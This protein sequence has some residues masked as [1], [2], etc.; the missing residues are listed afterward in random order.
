MAGMKTATVLKHVEFEGPSRISSILR[1]EG[2]ELDVR[3][4]HRGDPVPPAGAGG[5]LLVVMGG[6]MGV[7]DLGRPEYAF[8]RAEVD[9][10]RRRIEDDA[11]VLGVC[12]G[13]QLLAHAA[14]ARVYPMTGHDG[15]RRLEVGWG[16][17]RLLRGDDGLLDGLPSEVV[18]LHWHGD[19]FDVPAG[20]RLLASSEI[21]P[22]QA[23]R[24]RRSLFGLQ[25]HCESTAE[26]V[27]NWLREDADFVE[28]AN[29]PGAVERLRRETARHV[30]ALRGVGDRLLA[31]I[32][33][34]ATQA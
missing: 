17:I 21:C 11:P 20:A 23:F 5:D 1:D 16:P 4:L 32:V 18:V 12:L 3:S 22:N 31:R 9:L 13:A 34:A 24:L 26:D 19:T 2:Y 10:L 14:G 28:R 30:E 6:P 25:F 8:L 27:E 29:G 7:A 33:R 15:A